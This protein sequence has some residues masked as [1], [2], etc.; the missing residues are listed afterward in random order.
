MLFSGF[1][2]AADFMVKGDDK[3]IFRKFAITDKI[4]DPI[5][6]D[7]LGNNALNLL[8]RPIGPFALILC[9]LAVVLHITFTK[10]ISSVARHKLYLELNPPSDDGPQP[11]T[12]GLQE[13]RGGAPI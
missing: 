4:S 12:I 1:L 10:W 11:Q 6:N 9:A 7:G 3:F 5:E 13:P 2:V 8:I